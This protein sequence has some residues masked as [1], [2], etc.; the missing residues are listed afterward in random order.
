MLYYN[1]V[2]SSRINCD[3]DVAFLAEIKHY[4]ERLGQVHTEAIRN[5]YRHHV[6]HGL[7]FG[8]DKFFWKNLYRVNLAK[9][10]ISLFREVAR[11]A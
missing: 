11:L 6:A 7:L 9:V 8:S 3:Y 5:M 2:F 1:N 10:V 4:H